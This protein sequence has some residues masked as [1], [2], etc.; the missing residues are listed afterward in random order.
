MI[1]EWKVCNSSEIT[2]TKF[3]YMEKTIVL[4]DFYD[5]QYRI[6]ETERSIT[7]YQPGQR[8]IVLFKADAGTLMIF[9][10]DY[11]H[12]ELLEDG[13]YDVFHAKQG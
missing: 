1:Y 12:L 10:D 2:N 3:P 4:E 11:F 8:N 6:Y 5:Q 7:L 9:G 13:T